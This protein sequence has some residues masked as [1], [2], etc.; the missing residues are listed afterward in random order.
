MFILSILV[1]IIVLSIIY[2]IL[3]YNSLV[4]KKNRIRNSWSQID[5]QLKRRFDLIPNLVETI[6]GYSIYEKET[7]EKITQIR[8]QF[9][10]TNN[11]S[12]LIESDKNL[13]GVLSK[14]FAV[15]ENYPDL[16]ANFNFLELQ[17]E[18]TKTEEKISFS[19]LFYNDLVLD[20][21]NKVEIFPNNI[22]A[23]FLKFEKENY[24]ITDSKEKPNIKVQF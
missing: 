4:I 7:F 6:K 19:K 14:I 17:K 10:S 8:T 9:L 20:Y 15:A 12:Q 24:L 22:V 18:L 2:I 1:S 13:N 21:N 23:S 11:N 16:K 3:L 5:V